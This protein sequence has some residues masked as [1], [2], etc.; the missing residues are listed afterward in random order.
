MAEPFL[1]VD[2]GP[3]NAGNFYEGV[4]AAAHRSKARNDIGATVH[5]SF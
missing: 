1:Q 2:D 3:E 5:L 4:S